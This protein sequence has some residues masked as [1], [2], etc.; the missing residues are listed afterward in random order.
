MAPFVL[1]VFGGSFE[2][3]AQ[4]AAIAGTLVLA[5][6]L[7]AMGAYAYK[8]LRGGGVEWPDDETDDDSVSHGDTDD[9]WDYY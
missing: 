8:Q 5:L 1:Q 4:A 7:V 2:F 9:E 3:V 6:M